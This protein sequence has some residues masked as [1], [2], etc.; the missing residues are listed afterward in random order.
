MPALGKQRA[1]AAPQKQIALG[2]F[3]VTATLWRR[4]GPHP[5]R[6]RLAR[7]MSGRPSKPSLRPPP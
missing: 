3:F 4:R 7:L 1:G 5:G 2:A 6:W